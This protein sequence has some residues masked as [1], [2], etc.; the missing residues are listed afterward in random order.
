MSCDAD[1]HSLIASTS[2]LCD[3]GM[4]LGKDGEMWCS[5]KH[6]Y[7]LKISRDEAKRIGREIGNQDFS[8]TRHAGIQI[9]GTVY[10]PIGERDAVVIGHLGEEY[11]HM[12]ATNSAVV[13]A[14]TTS[15]TPPDHDLISKVVGSIA[16]SLIKVGL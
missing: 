4:I 7:A 16:G 2:G 3:S 8:E 12:Q 6:Q 9:N 14:H 5:A 11:V 13:I 1:L 15:T 10:L